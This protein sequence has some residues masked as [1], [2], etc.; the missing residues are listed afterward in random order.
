M[1]G[2]SG[3]TVLLC[4]AVGLCLLGGI[5]LGRRAPEKLPGVISENPAKSPAVSAAVPTPTAEGAPAELLYITPAREGYVSGDLVLKIPKLAVAVPVLDGVDA[6]TLLEGVGLYD[7]AQLP[8]EP[9]GNTSIAGHRNGLQN[10]II[11]DNMPFYYLDTLCRGDCL[12][13]TDESHIYQYA[14]EDQTVVEPD[15]W[16]PIYSQGFSC[17]TLTS[18][19]PITTATHR[20]V[21]QA[22]LHATLPRTAEYC[23]P[24][25]LEE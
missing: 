23:Y 9:E 7:Y 15:D 4:A 22:K 3:R 12:Y 19:T 24:T 20:I 10:G 1:K 5:L 16:G 25:A 8:D 11:T 13:L 17:L 6:A 21:I 18:C 14:F 2:K